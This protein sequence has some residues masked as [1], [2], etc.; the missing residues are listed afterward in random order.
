MVPTGAQQTK[1]NEEK[2]FR[3]SDVRYNTEGATSSIPGANNNIGPLSLIESSIYTRKLHQLP[4]QT[5]KIGINAL[6]QF[7]DAAP[8]PKFSPLLV[9]GVDRY[10]S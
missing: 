2:G 3:F 9:V 4:F 6:Q 7:P 8:P 10:G 5:I 1:D